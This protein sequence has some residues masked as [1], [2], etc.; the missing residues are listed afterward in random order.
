MEDRANDLVLV[1]TGKRGEEL[2]VRANW[3][4][5]E[6]ASPGFVRL[7]QFAATDHEEVQIHFPASAVAY[8]VGVIHN[9]M[10]PPPCSLEIL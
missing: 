6:E 7:R 1:A 2:R 5:M 9:S 10:Q 8:V 3:T 4:L